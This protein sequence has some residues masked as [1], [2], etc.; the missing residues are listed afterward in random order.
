MKKR[1]FTLYGIVQGV[2][3]RFFTA[4]EA[5]KIGVSGYVKN[6]SDGSVLVVAGGSA[7]QIER[8]RSWL[9]NGPP[10]ARVDRVIEQE[11]EAELDAGEFTVKH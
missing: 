1:Q 8:L 9:Q 11:Y 6:L 2:G 10:T 5:R 3:F 4:K 7:E